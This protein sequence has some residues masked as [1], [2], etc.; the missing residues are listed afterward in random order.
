MIYGS[1]GIGKSTFASKFPNP[2]FI[3]VEG[4]TKQ[5]NVKRTPSPKSWEELKL[6]VNEIYEN[7]SLCKTLVIDS[8]D[9]AEKL[10]A[11]YLCQ[12]SGVNGIEDFGYGKGYQYLEEE[13]SRMLRKLED[14]V[15]NKGMHVVFTAHAQMRK[16]EQPNERGAY[17]RWELKLS[18]KVAP[19][20]K[21]WSD[22]TLF[23]NYEIFTVKTNGSNNYKAEG[24]VR[25][26]WTSHNPCWD[27]KNRDNLPEVLPFDYSQI[28]KIF[29]NTEQKEKAEPAPKVE[30]APTPQAEPCTTSQV[31]ELEKK[32]SPQ[33][34]AVDSPLWLPAD[35][36][37]LLKQ[38]Q[39]KFE[40]V[41]DACIY[42]GHITGDTDLQ[43]MDKDFWNYLASHWEGVLNIIK[44]IKEK[45]ASDDMKLPF[46]I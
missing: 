36:R 44:E 37:N 22:L 25:K 13:F 45:L 5:L 20:V 8:A 9:W 34:S 10:C 24:G 6:I 18:R 27:A 29:E 46:E 4:G 26:M 23:V 14:L 2:L 38:S 17:D 3:D 39:V 42:R 19:L 41:V 21:E 15:V 35:F 28:A 11:Q 43:K 1:E 30:S 12:K 7:P 40:D 32:P 31:P 16:F 33:Q